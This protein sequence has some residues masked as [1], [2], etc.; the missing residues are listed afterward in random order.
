MTWPPALRLDGKVALVTGGSRGLGRHI[1]GAFAGAGATVVV[2]SR[3]LAAC[4]EAAREIAD[5]TGQPAVGLAC[6][7]GRWDDCDRLADTVLS[8]F[9]QVDVLVNNAGSSPRYDALDDVTEALFD[10]V[11]SVNL[12]GAFRL[13]ARLGT[14]MVRAGAGSIINISS[15]AAQR[16][17]PTELPYAAAKAGLDALTAGFAKAYAPAVRVNSIVP[18]MFATDISAAWDPD[19]VEHVTRTQIPLGRIGQPSEIVGAALYLASDA[20]S[21][22]TG[23]TLRVDGGQTA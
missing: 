11:L 21:F 14:E 16:P 9:G 6:H 7:V 10:K 5:Q 3:K 8:R 22:T 20:S 2:A 19:M 23:T 13:S 17:S 15:I 4:E 12:R 1:A 18:G